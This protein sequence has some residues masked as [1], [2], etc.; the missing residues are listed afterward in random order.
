[1]PKRQGESVIGLNGWDILRGLPFAKVTWS[2]TEGYSMHPRP[3][4]PE[5][6]ADAKFCRDCGHELPCPEA[7]FHRP[8]E[9]FK[10]V[11]AT[12][13][14]APVRYCDSG[15]CL[16]PAVGLTANGSRRCDYHFPRWWISDPRTI[17]WTDFLMPERQRWV[18]AAICLAFA[19]SVTLPI[20]GA[21]LICWLGGLYK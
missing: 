19:A 1:M 17:I 21:V 7:K 10:W 16:K 20:W 8:P 11:R 6:T 4:A 5:P 15:F 9:G 13:K 14:P 12:T 18:D 2:Q 3:L